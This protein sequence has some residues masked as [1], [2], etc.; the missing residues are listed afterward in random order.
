VKTIKLKQVSSMIIIIA[1][2]NDNL[3]TSRTSA[4]KEG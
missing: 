3:E 1:T 2:N 4:V